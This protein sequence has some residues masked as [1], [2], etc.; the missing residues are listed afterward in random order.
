M[1]R[2][3]LSIL[4]VFALSPPGSPAHADD[5][6]LARGVLKEAEAELR[7]CSE[8][9]E[10]IAEPWAD[11]GVAWVRC[12]EDREALRTALAWKKSLE[13]RTDSKRRDVQRTIARGQIRCGQLEP[14]LQNVHKLPCLETVL[15]IDMDRQ[16]AG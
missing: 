12:G 9:P 7:A 16:C 2:K 10:A 6:Q 4:V 15:R 3:A 13:I 11:L 1:S 8:K 14:L 5:L